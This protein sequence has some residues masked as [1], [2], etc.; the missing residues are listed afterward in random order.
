[1]PPRF[2]RCHNT[3]LIRPLGPHTWL[4]RL[5]NG[6]E[7]AVLLPRPGPGPAVP[8][9]E[10]ARVVVEISPADFAHG[11]V[12]SPLE[13]PVPQENSPRTANDL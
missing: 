4:G 7:L 13:A 2:V 5:P 6:H 1:M 12:L 8:A 11:R 10:G 9:T 3:V